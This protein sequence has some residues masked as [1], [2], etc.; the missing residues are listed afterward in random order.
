VKLLRL[1]ADRAL[2]TTLRGCFDRLRL[3]EHISGNAE[4]IVEPANHFQG[5]AAFTPQNL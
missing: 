3:D 1:T 5:Q 2:P 4:A